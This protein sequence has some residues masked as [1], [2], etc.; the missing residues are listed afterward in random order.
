[1]FHPYFIIQHL[2]SAMAGG[3]Y[4]SSLSS[5]LGPPRLYSI[6]FAAIFLPDYLCL[7]LLRFERIR[8]HRQS[9]IIKAI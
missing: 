4:A 6:I 1:M 3:G 7:R 2:S 8:L 5:G 9:R